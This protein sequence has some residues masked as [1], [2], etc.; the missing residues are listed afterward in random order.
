MGNVPVLKPAEVIAILRKLGW[1]PGRQERRNGARVRLYRPI[2]ERN[3]EA[4]D[5]PEVAEELR[6]LDGYESPAGPEALVDALYLQA[7]G[8]RPTPRELAAAVPLVGA[9]V[10]TEGVADLLW[11]LTMLPEFQLIN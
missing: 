7:L 4:D 8:R 11:A 2:V 1:A 10:R 9:P 5:P 3:L 6:T